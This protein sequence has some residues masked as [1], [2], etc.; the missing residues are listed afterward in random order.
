MLILWI[1]VILSLL[2]K[3]LL[4]PLLSM[5]GDNNEDLGLLFELYIEGLNIPIFKGFSEFNTNPFDLDFETPLLA[6]VILGD[7]VVDVLIT[8]SAI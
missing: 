2:P 7:A 1:D 3:Q 6:L 4:F 8:Y 5:F